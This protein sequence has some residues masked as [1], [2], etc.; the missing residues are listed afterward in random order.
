M[1]TEFTVG[2][3]VWR[4]DGGTPVMTIAATN[5][6]HYRCAWLDAD[7]QAQEAWYAGDALELAPLTLSNGTTLFG[8]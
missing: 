2:T 1:N 8:L 4:K 3:E 7:G 6:D 5:G